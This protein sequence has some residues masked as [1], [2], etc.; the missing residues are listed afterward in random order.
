MGKKPNKPPT[1]YLE[2]VIAKALTSDLKPGI[3]HVVVEH[4][5]HCP[6]INGGDHCA[7]SPTVTL[8]EGN[9]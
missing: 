1:G 4:E 7:C 8:C 2:Q 3:Q 9:A 6:A 5:D